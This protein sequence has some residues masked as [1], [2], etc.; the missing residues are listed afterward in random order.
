MR[1]PS[2]VF[3]LPWVACVALSL[4]LVGQNRAGP[5]RLPGE[6]REHAELAKEAEGW[7]GAIE[8]DANA[9][10]AW[11]K[12][13]D[14][15]VAAEA[16]VARYLEDHPDDPAV[17]VLR[18]RLLQLVGLHGNV[19]TGRDGRVVWRGQGDIPARVRELLRRAVALAPP[20]WPEPH[21]RL[22][23]VYLQP[24]VVD[25]PAGSRLANQPDS[26]LMAAR[27]ALELD[28]GKKQY[29]T[30]VG[31]ASLAVGDTATALE[32]LPG[33]EEKLRL[34]GRIRE[35]L[36]RI[37]LPPGARRGT[38][39]VGS[40]VAMMSSQDSFRDYP[41]ERVRSW[42]VPLE[43]DE[44]EAFY[45]ERWEGF[46]LLTFED[47]TEGSGEGAEDGGKTSTFVQ[48]FRWE[49]EG[50]VPARDMEEMERREG[51]DGLGGVFLTLWPQAEVPE[52]IYGAPGAP[53]EFASRL[54]LAE[55][56]LESL[57]PD[58]R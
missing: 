47:G 39:G 24:R 50:P 16:A 23:R 32:H 22:A 18:A 27:R 44:I 57:R 54:P 33:L 37:P 30:L 5:P 52:R 36:E 25:G 3:V 40:Y 13:K 34:L 6:L 49:K 38:A 48:H 20:G 10:F 1:M 4:P 46:R 12:N 15:M 42:L 43:V 7:H 8:A 21:Y 17:L 56:V 41:A 51:K 26:A 58:R 14:R 55:I 28:P 9:F 53:P 11:A 45:R 29:R 2:K 35:D 31:E 19:L